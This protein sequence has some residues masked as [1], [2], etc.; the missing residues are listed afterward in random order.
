MEDGRW[1][2]EDV[3]Y[4]LDGRRLSAKPSQKGIYIYKGKKV[5]I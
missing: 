3:W 2:M 1:K 5:C 4:T